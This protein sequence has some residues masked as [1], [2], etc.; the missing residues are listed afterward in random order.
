MPWVGRTDCVRTESEWVGF[1]IAGAFRKMHHPAATIARDYSTYNSSRKG[2]AARRTARDKGA[3][4]A[5][6]TDAALWMLEA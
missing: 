3:Y 5:A 1:F 6:A 2:A 4:G